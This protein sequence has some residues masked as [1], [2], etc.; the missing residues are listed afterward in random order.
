[1]M[2]ILNGGVH[3]DNP[4][5]FQEFMIVPLGAASFAEALRAGAEI[6][7]TLRAALKAA[8]LNTNV[9]DEGGF[10]PDLPSAEAALDQ[11]V[12]AIE[13]AGYRA[14]ERCR[15]RA[16]SRLER[17]FQKRRLP[18]RRRGQDTLGRPAGR[19]SRPNW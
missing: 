5:D 2:N 13:K 1:M 3:A 8:G 15:D 7:H 9:G 10:A 6:F 4:I 18:L 19:I 14:G 17:I 11:V 16:R 12:A